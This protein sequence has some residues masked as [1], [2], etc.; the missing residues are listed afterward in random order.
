MVVFE[1]LFGLLPDVKI[2][3]IEAKFQK[4]GKWK[5]AVGCYE[6]NELLARKVWDLVWRFS[7]ELDLLTY[8]GYDFA[9]ALKERMDNER[10]PFSRVYHEQPQRLARSLATQVDIRTIYDPDPSHQFL[11]GGKG[12]ILTPTDAHLLLGAL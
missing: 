9:E 6:I 1:G 10:M 11:Y 5:E 7:I 4:R 12:R 3:G 8:L 2:K